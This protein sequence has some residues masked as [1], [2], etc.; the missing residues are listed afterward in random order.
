MRLR[1]CW[2]AHELHRILKPD[3]EEISDHVFQAV[4]CPTDLQVAYTSDGERAPMSPDDLVATFLDPA[5]DYVQAVVLGESGTGK[6][7]L[8]QWLRMNI[9]EDESTVLLT[10]PRAGTSLRGIVE[11]IVDRLPEVERG[12]YEER[13]RSTGTVMASQEA[14]V[15]K[16]LSELALAIQHGGRTTDPEDVDLA[17]LLPNLLLDPTF[18]KGFFL[19]SGGTVDLIVQH[20]FV[21][22]ERRDSGI[23]RREFRLGDLPLDGRR[24][25][26][27]AKLAKEAIDY[28]KDEEGL[29]ARAIALMN[30]NLPAAIAQT[31]NFSADHLIDLMNALRRY[32]ARQGKRLILLI[33]DF[34][35]LQGIDTALLQA[36]ITPPGQGE[37]RL[38]ELRWAMAVTTGYYKRLEATVLSRT[39]LLVDMDL[40]K[41]ASMQQ[42]TS[43]YL[44]ALRMGETILRDTASSE[45]IRSRCETCEFRSTCLPAFGDV[46]GKGL[47]PFTAKA[48]DIMA[49]RTESLG[50]DGRFNAR[51]FLRRVL[52]PVLRDHYP[53]LEHGEFPSIALLKRIGGTDALRP[54]D[55]DQLERMDPSNF[56]RRNVL[57]ELWDGSGKLVNLSDGVQSAFGMPALPDL[58]ESP[59][60]EG[61][62]GDG[63]LPSDI[64][65]RPES[66]PA[67]IDLVRKWERNAAMLPQ[68]LVT[69][70]REMI[71][72]ALGSFVDWDAIGLRKASVFAATG[73]SPTVFAPTSINFENQQTV[74][75]KN[76]LIS[77]DLGTDAAL[78]MEAVL[79]YARHHSWDF[80]DGEKLLAHLLEALRKWAVRIE[81]QLKDVYGAKDGWD[82]A[83]AA[84]ELL[85]LAA[86]RSGRI[87]IGD[88]LS[89]LTAAQM[90]EAGAPSHFRSLDSE[91]TELNAEIIRQWPRL[92]E[93]LRN[94]S[95][96]T[97][98]GVAGNFVRATPVVRTLRSLRRDLKL[99]QCSPDGL[100]GKGLDEVARLY[101]RAKEKF[102]P[103][104][105][106]EKEHW[107]AW[108]VEMES[109]I[110]ETGKVADLVRALRQAI[111]SALTYGLSTGVSANR[112][113]NTLNMPGISTL[114]RTVDHV[115]A[116][117]IATPGETLLR[118]A[119][120]IDKRDVLQQVVEHGDAFL[121]SAEAALDNE[122]A[123]LE[124][125]SGAGL[126]E[127][128]SSIARS[129]DSLANS[130]DILCQ[131][132]GENV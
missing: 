54:I 111:E 45:S 48:I 15:G 12:P 19:T 60:E 11:R 101:A 75:R 6:S 57:L 8:I 44:N 74:R 39:T 1:P 104:L 92:L 28:I 94:L 41:P 16:F 125:R 71:H 89:E 113:A 76:L 128:E 99:S 130:L 112:L 3:A 72:S 118:I 42:L 79:L 97:K 117:K 14:K 131:L 105:E 61:L 22:P 90:W 43:G 4:H 23:E 2:S 107:L 120:V 132:Q 58:G 115:R 87:K 68:A 31:L 73:A 46:D 30:R 100:S 127:S 126:R 33:E 119:A 121:Q 53:D 63:E 37:E 38:C 85:A 102:L 78:A 88:T 98:G 56:S 35:R 20:I 34:A 40:S 21:D 36:L 108:T 122:S 51:R 10:I 13:L 93:L 29:E 83:T 59:T 106:R 110:G 114:D 65:Y 82:P 24:Y 47:F 25:Q 62:E 32:L 5:R 9:P 50:E 64:G 55:R 91:F 77:L 96:G 81:E 70:L 129:L 80:P 49:K 26:D 17:S 123:T 109:S 69:S 124:R 27:A 116:L 95:S 7:H 86:Y 66:V 84:A 18:R 67:E 103:G 52:E